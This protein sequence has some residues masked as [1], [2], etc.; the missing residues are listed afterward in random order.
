MGSQNFEQFLEKALKVPI[1]RK[2]FGVYRF[3]RNYDKKQ[4]SFADNLPF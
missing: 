3:N 4:T 1:L 2:K